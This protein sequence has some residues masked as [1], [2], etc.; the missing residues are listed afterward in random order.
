MSSLIAGLKW[1]GPNLGWVSSFLLSQF[2]GRVSASHI[3]AFRGLPIHRRSGTRTAS[4]AARPRGNAGRW[5]SNAIASLT[6]QTRRMADERCLCNRFSFFRG[7]IKCHVFFPVQPLAERAIHTVNG[8]CHPLMV[9]RQ[10]VEGVTAHP[11][12]VRHPNDAILECDQVG[13]LA[14]R[15]VV[16][17]EL[18]TPHSWTLHYD[19]RL[20]LHRRWINHRHIR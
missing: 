16:L 4:S 6:H 11:I 14:C 19:Y 13:D 7:E 5:R 8:R 3:N 1:G 20:G 2:P 17:L 9:C 18:G 10:I 12:L 15:R